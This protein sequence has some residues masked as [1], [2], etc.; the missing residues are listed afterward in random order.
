MKMNGNQQAYLLLEV[1][2]L[3]VYMDG[4]AW[5]SDREFTLTALSGIRPSSLT[6]L[7]LLKTN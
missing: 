7:N 5:G 3:S 6:H 1:S 4:C 2:G